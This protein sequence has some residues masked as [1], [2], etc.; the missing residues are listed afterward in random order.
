MTDSYIPVEKV[1]HQLVGI[2]ETEGS[3]LFSNV[4]KKLEVDYRIYSN[5]QGLK[6]WLLGFPQFDKSE[7]GLSLILKK[8]IL[9][10]DVINQLVNVLKEEG[11][12]L[13]SNVPHRLDPIDYKDYS[14]GQGLKEWLLSFPQFDKSEDERSLILKKSMPL[15]EVID[16]LVNILKEEGS[17]RFSDVPERLKPIDY[18]DYS[19]GQGL[20][21]WLLS[22]P[23]FGR[24]EDGWS[25]ISSQQT[26]PVSTSWEVQ[27]MHRFAYMNYWNQNLKQLRN[28]GDFSSLKVNDL[29]DHIAR[30]L[31]HDLMVGDLLIDDADPQA[32]HLILNTGLLLPGGQETYAVLSINPFNTDDRKQFWAMQGF[33]CAAET[34]TSWLGDWLRSYFGNCVAFDYADL[35]DR[36]EKLSETAVLM[37]AETRDFL[38][39]LVN[40]TCPKLADASRFSQHIISYEQ[41]WDDLLKILEGFPNFAD[42]EPLTLSD[43]REVINQETFRTGLIQQALAAFDTMSDGLEH[44]FAENRWLSDDISTPASDRK[45]LHELYDCG[46]LSDSNH[47]GFRKI[48][49]IY[50]S[51]RAVMASQRA[52]DDYYDHFLKA[53]EHFQELP[54]IRIASRGVLI[55][56]PGE[57]R[58]FLDEIDNIDRFLDQYIASES[59]SKETDS[60]I[61]LPQTNAELLQLALNADRAY[62]VN[63]PQYLKLALPENP[64]VCGLVMRDGEELTCYGAAK[65]LLSAGEREYAERYLVLGLQ[66]EFERCAPTLL[67]LYREYGCEE[68]FEAVWTQFNGRVDCASEDELFWF[69][70]VCTRSPEQALETAQTN[71]QLQYQPA[72]L[73]GLIAA[74]ERLNRTDLAE[75]YRTRLERFS[76]AAEPDELETAIISGD[77]TAIAEAILPEHLQEMG[78]D[79]RQIQ[80]IQNT[81]EAGDYP[82]GN[83]AYM[84]G[85][86]L[87][88]FQSNRHS[89]AERWMWQGVSKQPHGDYAKLLLL[90][91]NEQR[92]DEAIALYESDADVQSRYDACRRFYLLSRFYSSPVLAQKAFA[93]NLQDVLEIINL[94]QDFVGRFDAASKTPG[95]EFYAALLKLHS[96]VSNPYIWSII[97][98]DRSLRDRI[99]DQ[100]QLES[101][102]LDPVRISEVYRSGE[103]PHG[104]DAASIAARLY[105]LAGNL[106]GAAETAAQLA[107][108]DVS[109][110][111]LLWTIYA[112]DQDEVA[113]YELLTHDEA[114]RC[115]HQTEYLNFIF[116]RE[117]YA[118]FLER[119]E[120]L[121]ELSEHR[122]LQ[123]ATA[124]LSCSVPMSDPPEACAEAAKSCS[125]ELCQALLKVA[126]KTGQT[127]LV[128]EILCTCFDQWLTQ[129]PQHLHMLV[130]C[131]AMADQALCETVQRS[132]LER[133]VPMLAVYIQ[134]ELKTG[135]VWQHA[136]LLYSQLKDQLGSGTPEEKLLCIQKLQCLYPDKA[137]SLSVQATQYSIEALLSQAETMNRKDIAQKLE[138]C[139]NSFD[140]DPA[141]FDVVTPL[142]SG[143]EYC[144]DFR[145]YTAI[146]NFGKRVGRS[147]D[148]LRFLH[149]AGWMEGSE[150]KPYFR[151]YLIKLYYEALLQGCFP[152]EI[153]AEAEQICLQSID[154]SS[155][156]W[157]ALSLYLLEQLANRPIY[158][159]TVVNHLINSTDGYF[160]SL[161]ETLSAL[162]ADIIPDE[163]LLS[164]GMPTNLQLFEQILDSGSEDEILDY[165][166]FCKRFISGNTSSLQELWNLRPDQA[167]SEQQSILALELLCSDPERAE[168]WDLC[169]HVFFNS[170]DMGRAKFLYLCCRKNPARW[171]EYVKLCETL[172]SAPERLPE[173]LAC[174]S[175]APDPY[176]EECRL[177]L[178]NALEED[179]DYLIAMSD[180]SS[181]C[182]LT[183]NL[184]RQL[185]QG[186]K[187]AQIKAVSVIA[188][189]TGSRE[190]LKILQRDA[191]HLLFGVK[192]DLG[193]AVL[194][195]LFLGDRIDEAYEWLSR[196]S[197]SIAM[198]KYRALVD[199]LSGFDR[200]ELGRWCA[201]PSNKTFLK[202]I[203]PD[204]NQPNVE[205]ITNITTQ[206]LL[207]GT[208]AETAMVLVRLLNI[209]PDDY[210]TS[211]ELFGL[212]KTGFEGSIPMLHF[213]LVNLSRLPVPGGN[214]RIY[215]AR[216]QQEHAQALAIL[217]QLII[218][219]GQIDSIDDGWE[220]EGSTVQGLENVG[221]VVRRPDQIASVERLVCD[222]L[223]NQPQVIFSLRVCAW[224]ANITGNWT[225]YLKRSFEARL[226]PKAVF[227]PEDNIGAFGMTRSVLR[228]FAQAATE[229][230]PLLKD[231]MKKIMRR[232]AV[233]GNT[234][235]WAETAIRSESRASQVNL[236]IRMEGE[237]LLSRLAALEDFPLEQVLRFP[238]EDYGMFEKLSNTVLSPALNKGTAYVYPIAYLLCAIGGNAYVMQKMHSMAEKY[239]HG[240]QDEIAWCFYTALYKTAAALNISHGMAFK[241][242]GVKYNCI[243]EKEEYQTR[244]RIAGAFSG[245][246]ACVKKL[247]DP[248]LSAW[249][250]INLVLSLANKNSNRADEIH[251]LEEYLDPGR[252]SVAEKVLFI[253]R[254]D[255]DDEEKIQQVLNSDLDRLDRYYLTYILKYPYEYGK[256][257]GFERSDSEK[258]LYCLNDVRCAGRVD[259]ENRQIWK[260]MSQDEKDKCI[261]SFRSKLLIR[262]L[263]RENRDP[264]ICE[265]RDPALWVRVNINYPDKD[266][267][268]YV[269]PDYA[270]A[271]APLEGNLDELRALQ[272]RYDQLPTGNSHKRFSEKVQISEEI[273]RRTVGCAEDDELCY[274]ALLRYSVD[275]VYDLISDGTPQSRV[276][277]FRLIVPL[278][279]TNGGHVR[280]GAEYEALTEMVNA[281]GA[282]GLIKS[283]SSI[284][285]L[286][287][288]YAD[289]KDAFTRL[290]GILRDSVALRNISSIFEVLEKLG[291]VFP[292]Y[293]ASDVNALIMELDESD[294]IIGDVSGV[295]WADVKSHLQR[296]I[297]AERNF[298]SRR[299][300]L[301]IRLLN[302]GD[303]PRQG[304]FYGVVTNKGTVAAESLTLQAYYAG[305]NSSHQYT[306]KQ[307]LANERAVFEVPY[308]VTGDETSLSGH[309]DLVGK[310]GETMISDQ[311]DFAFTIGETSGDT[312]KYNT[313]TTD[314]AG[315]FTYD[316]ETHTVVNSEFIGRSEETAWMR[317]L[318]AEPSFE[319]YHSAMVYGVRR[320]GKTSLLEYFKAYVCGTN[321]DCL[322]FRVDVQTTDVTI[323][324]VFI[325]SVLKENVVAD[326]LENYGDREAFTQ[327][328]ENADVDEEPHLLRNFFKEL[329]KATGK[330]LILIVDEIDRLFGRLIDDHKEDKFHALLKALSG[331]LDDDGC[332]ECVHLVICGSNWLMY[333][334]SVGF[335]GGPDTHQLFHRIG[336]YQIE[337]G[338]LPIED[339][340]T[341]LDRAG[342]N[343]TDEAKQ[344]IWEYTGGLVWF[345]KLLGNAAIR[346]AKSKNR[347][348]I[349]PSDVSNSL[350]DVLTPQN[351]QQFY[352]GCVAGGL[353][354]QMIDAMQSLAYRKDMNIPV[355]KICELLG[356]D[357]DDVVQA[358]DN[359]ILFKI[360][361]KDRVNPDLVHFSL[362][363]YRRYFRTIHSRFER[364]PE[365]PDTFEVKSD[366]GAGI[367]MVSVGEAFPDDE[368]F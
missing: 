79:P 86:R 83:G 203:L 229:D 240:G 239:F 260:S 114:L 42:N 315:V 141:L 54:S 309:M 215:Y 319:Q 160:E 109:A 276:Q 50:R 161:Q 119:I 62:F 368:E 154:Q 247:A 205:Q 345:T 293:G 328:W 242:S 93:E 251:R 90:L 125:P 218:Y 269:A 208:E 87:Y 43:I 273:Y 23:Q 334:A 127:G 227:F 353:E 153:A 6:A 318:V 85:C 282:T 185:K 216:T 28:L 34:D 172:P 55:D 297:R 104:R 150:K 178:E 27:C 173:A 226:E 323:Q 73:I 198:I 364:I 147:D 17:I 16:R 69:G 362:D 238:A 211:Y 341:V 182:L 18:K 304:H 128:T 245:N 207:N 25:L 139:I 248:K 51:L 96:A 252:V 57:E 21:A 348:C 333:Y 11:S 336:D 343:Y 254:T 108:G 115:E 193:V 81:A 299:A 8:S 186:W 107:L 234:P 214:S 166:N 71:L 265:Q 228:L 58:Q 14:N 246:E 202:M 102:G 190:C 68:S 363:I 268:V 278:L 9:P 358:L 99:R 133:E 209:F 294:Q 159:D 183:Q 121:P 292:L 19:N 249:S 148:T 237:C 116:A 253:L 361:E 188:V 300:I 197:G 137:D 310:S 162:G 342:V 131:S 142:L 194:S 233:K 335:D 313:Y 324:S 330:G 76:A 167:M 94:R 30:R 280:G 221:A 225:E 206:A 303:Q 164:D 134:N 38:A 270:A 290:R 151:E 157:A 80:S 77:R 231:W 302:Q 12:I 59:A 1:I 287:E 29:R 259:F 272:K 354:L 347:S 365:V 192:S 120:Q 320:T 244:M 236:A 284:R 189:S 122:L 199:E 255:T 179:P 92:W 103:Y 70:I 262:N 325:D 105:A 264:R 100:A 67:T 366:T 165:L 89:L 24:S 63:W 257:D 213:S 35:S 275:R 346:R 312:L 339:T 163:L 124:Q 223:N 332:K 232:P 356:K 158:A 271:L 149:R 289:H 46:T 31:M 266:E 175:G 283:Y 113:M 15:E 258:S 326:A 91:T 351:C 338:R 33:G 78:F 195:R 111:R 219:Q 352:E 61:A 2:L 47:T 48:L 53:S 41:Q 286:T 291:K 97:S 288:D 82:A 224:M 26:I 95:N 180:D 126:A 144:W 146:S 349:Y 174:W 210:T 177:Y 170:S 169:A 98:E 355:D 110:Q 296:M 305:T 168:Y 101:L 360:V 256:S 36:I 13:F 277:A 52:D 329:K 331:I 191:G 152:V 84:V 4:P 337:V 314:R 187:H 156:P 88:A 56:I 201:E 176:A 106:S 75:R 274:R 143:T 20:Q 140:A 7:D 359:L 212:C 112:N 279:E 295:G 132:A 204:G 241:P 311:R 196:L 184:C 66:Y 367:C 129:A 357:P 117:E 306:L 130:S 250:T 285:E 235:D 267:Y 307:L 40:E 118:D 44:F 123:R 138:A 243:P 217:N 32:P 45:Y 72:C 200:D 350:K 65:R 145:V 327:Q 135:D 5:G 37:Q 64:D 155:S 230:V 316:P 60:G 181:M 308:E 136:D 301:E 298:L 317:E 22:F 321:P 322:C 220:F 281:V 10:E 340:M 261:G 171:A 74:A 49:D 3:I 344:M 263:T 222:S 39:C